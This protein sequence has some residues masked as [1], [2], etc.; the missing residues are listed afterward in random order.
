MKKTPINHKT[1]TDA[2]FQYNNNGQYY[3]KGDVM[4]TLTVG[5]Q[6]QLCDPDNIG[7]EGYDTMEELYDAV[8]RGKIY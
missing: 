7:N 8:N 4:V 2:G 1:L 3:Q 5:N 6:W